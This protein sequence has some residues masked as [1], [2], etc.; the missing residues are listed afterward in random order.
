MH[1]VTDRLILRDFASSDLHD[2]HEIFSD[3]EVMQFVEPPYTLK[4]TLDFLQDFCIG[5]NPPGACAAVDKET[6][7]VVG[8]VLFKSLHYPEIYEMGWIFHKNYWR[9]GLAYEAC[10]ALI[11]YGFT[12]LKLHKICAETIDT[13]KSVP[14]MMKLGMV[15]DGIQRKHTRS[16]DGIWTDV[17]WYAILAEDYLK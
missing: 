2:L 6:G 1:I 5:R 4:K 9:K 7:K 14:L 11:A 13:A 3:P 15:S 8:Y 12:A 17:H 10:H 16:L